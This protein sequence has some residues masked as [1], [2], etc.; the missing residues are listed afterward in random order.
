M[1]DWTLSPRLE[2]WIVHG[3]SGKPFWRDPKVKRSALWYFFV[4]F[5]NRFC[6]GRKVFVIAHGR[7]ADLI[8]HQIFLI[9]W[10]SDRHSGSGKRMANLKGVG[11]YK[12]SNSHEG[13]KLAGA[14]ATLCP[15]RMPAS[16]MRIVL[17]HV[18]VQL[19]SKVEV[20]GNSLYLSA[21][22]CTT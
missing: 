2:S 4:C 9:T 6:G 1:V 13:R 3:R 8:G 15:F 14:G 10:M 22:A 11:R 19:K 7:F 12:K 5:Y 18:R 21:I 20:F 17:H 16:W